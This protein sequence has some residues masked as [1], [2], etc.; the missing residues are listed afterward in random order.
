MFLPSFL[1][2]REWVS[3]WA[4]EWVSQSVSQSVSEWVSVWA[5]ERAS[6]GWGNRAWNV[7][8][9]S[10]T[11]TSGA[12]APTFCCIS[13]KPRYILLAGM[14][15]RRN[16]PEPDV[17]PAGRRVQPAQPDWF[18][19]KK[20][21]WFF[22][23][24]IHPVVLVVHACQPVVRLVVDGCDGCTCLPAKCTQALNW[25][26]KR[27]VRS[28]GSYLWHSGSGR[29]RLDSPSRRSLARSLAH[30]LTHWLTDWLTHSLTRSIPH[31]LTQAKTAW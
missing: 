13:W 29:S 27:M 19:I 7:L 17:Q 9:L 24:E 23:L 21:N 30:T 5:S 2:L 4:S 26:N 6:D 14:Y 1:S 31:S 8:S 28:L 18:L 3:D 16:R 11:N 10:A 22:L 15:N 20:K 25:Y 12:T